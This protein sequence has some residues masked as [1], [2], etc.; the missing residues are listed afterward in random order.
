MSKPHAHR[1]GTTGRFTPVP[2]PDADTP[3]V[4]VSGDPQGKHARPVGTLYPAH[5]FT[6]GPVTRPIPQRRARMI[7]GSAHDYDH[8]ARGMD[9]LFNGGHLRAQAHVLAAHGDP[10]I[11]SLVS[12]VGSPA[13]RARGRA[14]YLAAM[15]R[16][17]QQEH[18]TENNTQ[19]DE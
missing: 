6:H 11:T 8:E 2:V 19:N 7:D 14:A 1:D 4:N 3:V 18:N 12:P 16:A 5:D 17:G 9:T 15:D 10:L 13:A